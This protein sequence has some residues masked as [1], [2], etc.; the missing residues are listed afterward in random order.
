MSAICDLVL[1]GSKQKHHQEPF[2]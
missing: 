1:I 2:L